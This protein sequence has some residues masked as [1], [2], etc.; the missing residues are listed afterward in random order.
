VTLTLEQIRAI[1][2]V[3]DEALDLGILEEPLNALR[4]TSREGVIGARIEIYESKPAL[5]E[6]VAPYEGKMTLVPDLARSR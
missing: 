2:D 3:Y 1:Q 4:T 5:V 6:T